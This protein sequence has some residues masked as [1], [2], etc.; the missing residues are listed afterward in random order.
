MAN[1]KLKNPSGGSL[2]LVSADG[3]S[4]LTVTFP[5][6]TGTAMVS[7]NMP[8]FSAY[9]N[10]TQSLSATVFTKM[11]LNVEEFD[12][13]NNFDSTTNYRFTPTVAGYYQINGAVTYSGTGVARILCS[14][15]KNGSEY[16]RGGDLLVGGYQSG[17]SSILYCN[18]TTDYIELYGW[19]SGSSGLGTSSS[20]REV[21]MNGAMV[22]AA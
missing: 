7:G 14:I 4:D 12:T 22:R 10:T 6:T 9:A 1:L 21:Y 20:S 17:V 11:Q 18:G 8:A 19:I 3:G 2:N 16:K 13:N 15:Y 5:A